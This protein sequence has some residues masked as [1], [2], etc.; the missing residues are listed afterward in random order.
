MSTQTA[1]N[2]ELQTILDNLTCP[3]CLGICLNS[4]TLDEQVVDKF[5][6]IPTHETL[7]ECDNCG[8][9]INLKD[10]LPSDKAEEENECYTKIN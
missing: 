3:E 8:H 7:V 2:P 5:T 4:H 10:E 1:L 6:R 9:L